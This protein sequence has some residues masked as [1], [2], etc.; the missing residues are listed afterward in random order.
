MTY[1]FDDLFGS[2]YLLQFGIFHLKQ[3]K[4]EKIRRKSKKSKKSKLGQT[5]MSTSLHCTAKRERG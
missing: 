1:N 5:L 2:E 4:D 3:Q